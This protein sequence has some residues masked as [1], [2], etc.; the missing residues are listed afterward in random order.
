M[1]VFKSPLLRNLTSFGNHNNRSTD[2]LT[3]RT[4]LTCQSNYRPE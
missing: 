2:N 1:Y 3:T 4:R